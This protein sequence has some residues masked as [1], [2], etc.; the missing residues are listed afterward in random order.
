[1]KAWNSIFIR[2][3]NNTAYTIP[4]PCRVRLHEF[5]FQAETTGATAVT[6]DFIIDNGQGNSVD[7]VT[8]SLA[9]FNYSAFRA[10][11]GNSNVQKI[12]VNQD[13]YSVLMRTNGANPYAVLINFT[14]NPAKSERRISKHFR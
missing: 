10:V 11:A 3:P 14:Y 7:W 2:I 5:Y 8:S 12:L 9:T 6:F 1:M 4:F 13:A